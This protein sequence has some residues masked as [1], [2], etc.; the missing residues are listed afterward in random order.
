MKIMERKTV[1]D[2]K[3]VIEPLVL[4]RDFQYS[5]EVFPKLLSF[6]SA[7]LG[8]NFCLEIVLFKSR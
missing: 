7:I 4:F 6:S 2:Y 8:A 3:I 5:A 1:M